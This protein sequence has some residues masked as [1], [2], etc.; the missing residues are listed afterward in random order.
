MDDNKTFKLK[1]I[2]PERAFYENDAFMLEMDTAEGEV[3]IYKGHI[4]M[5]LVLKPGIVTIHESNEVKKAAVHGGF[6][7]ILPD[8]VTLLAEIA[9][10]PEEIDY[11]RAEEARIRAERRLSSKDP[12]INLTKAQIALKKALIREELA[13]K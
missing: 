8:S 2:T 13:K 12:S 10:W 4:P 6:A 1:I 11:N 9:E 7:E 3:G 5:T